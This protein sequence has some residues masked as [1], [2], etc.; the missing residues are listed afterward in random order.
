M[1]Y[2]SFFVLVGKCTVEKFCTENVLFGLAVRYSY[3]NPRLSY[4][5]PAGCS[6]WGLQPVNS[7]NFLQ[8]PPPPN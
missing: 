8:L 4:L 2:E 3:N 6:T 1:I 5:F 7:D